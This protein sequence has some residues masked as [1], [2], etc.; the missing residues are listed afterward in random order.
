ML[1]MTR[2]SLNDR[3][4]WE[5]ANVKLPKFDVQAVVDATAKAPVR[6]T[7]SAALLLRFS[8]TC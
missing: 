3:A 7:F 2:N 6:E 4:A 5:K 1:H 8:S